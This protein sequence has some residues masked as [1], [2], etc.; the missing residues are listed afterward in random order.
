MPATANASQLPPTSTTSATIRNENMISLALSFC[1]LFSGSL[2][3]HCKHISLTMRRGSCAVDAINIHAFAPLYPA[4]S[5]IVPGLP[6]TRALTMKL[7]K[8][9]NKI[10]EKKKL[11]SSSVALAECCQ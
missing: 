5:Y 9:K 11:S 4:V 10:N 1:L 3:Y 6:Q 2:V 7:I 8:I